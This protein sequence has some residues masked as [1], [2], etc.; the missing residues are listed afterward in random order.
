MVLEALSQEFRGCLPYELLYDDDLVLLADGVD[1]LE[2]KC[3]GWK[4]GMED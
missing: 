2:G 1:E 4:E 3:S